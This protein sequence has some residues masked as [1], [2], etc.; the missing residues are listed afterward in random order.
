LFKAFQEI[1]ARISMLIMSLAPAIAAM[2]AYVFLHETLSVTGVLGIFVTVGGIAIVVLGRR[3]ESAA[4]PAFTPVGVLYALLGAV[5]Q[6]GGLIFAKLAFQES[7]I[8]GFVATI[9]RIIASL[10]ILLPVA[11]LTRRFRSPFRMY[12]GDR[13]AFGLTALG[14]VLG[15]F[16]G[17]SFSLIAVANAKVGIAATI[18]AIVPVLMLPL[19]RYVYGE[20]LGWRAIGGAAVAVAGVGLLFLR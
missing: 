1:G 16:L 6:G 13:K 20:R 5:G 15:P 12:A 14:A 10:A 8:N 17:I 3:V 9:I 7:T 11:A 4:E 19:V 2:L 18:M